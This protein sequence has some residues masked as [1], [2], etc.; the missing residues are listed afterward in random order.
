MHF[1]PNNFSRHG[2]APCLS[3]VPNVRTCVYYNAFLEKHPEFNLD[4]FEHPLTGNIAPGML[5]IDG[6]NFN[7]DTLFAARMIKVD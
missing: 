6:G 4:P 7:C 3:F 1:E 5:R 2:H